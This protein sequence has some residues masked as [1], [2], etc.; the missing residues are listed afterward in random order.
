MLA[1]TKEEMARLDR[2]TIEEVG[3]PE[4]VLME[5]AGR[6]VS[7]QVM[8]SAR[9][10]RVATVVC[11]KGNNGGDGLVAARYLYERGVDARVFLLA[12]ESKISGSAGSNLAVL[13]KMGIEVREV[14]D[15]AGLKELQSS[16]KESDVAVDAVFGIG[17]SGQIEGIPASAVDLINDSR[18]R[19]IVSVDVPSGINSDTGEADSRAVRADVTVT[20]AYPKVG[21]LKHP[22]SELAGRLVTADIG[23]PKENPLH[24][25]KAKAKKPHDSAT[26]VITPE[27]VSSRIPVRPA[28]AH[29]GTCGSVL[30]VAG[31]PGMTG[32]ALLT[33]KAA[34]RS[35]AGLVRACVPKSQAAVADAALPEMITVGLPE[36]GSGTLSDKALKDIMALYGKCDCLALGPGLSTQKG[37]VSLVRK[38]LKDIAGSRHVKPMVIDAD[39]LNAIADDISVLGALSHNA[40]ITPHP[41]E[42]ARIAGISVDEVQRSREDLAKKLS[43]NYGIIVVLKGSK[44]VVAKPGSSVINLTGNPGMAQAGMGDALTGAIAGF[45]AQGM[46]P[47]DASCAG[48]FVHGMAGDVVS[49]IKGDRGF[50]ASDLIDAIPYVMNSIMR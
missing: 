19:R 30:I 31:S 23:I 20:F 47:F 3:I 29:K 28:S 18:P 6:A 24:P 12:E 1:V 32:A 46:K 14:A 42:M 10:T 39:A 16:L 2:W 11:G 13:K 37:T 45:L 33:S 48:V 41:G 8:S 7:E 27:F 36:T 35:G 50:M 25:K 9:G 21:L 38:L 44:T 34:L 15:E 40:V 4:I 17:F 5:N 49:S 26:T 22:A 43:R